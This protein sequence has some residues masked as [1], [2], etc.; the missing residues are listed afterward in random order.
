MSEQTEQTTTEPTLLQESPDPTR[1]GRSAPI[2]SDAEASAALAEHQAALVRV[3]EQFRLDAAHFESATADWRSAGS[4][5]EHAENVAAARS[6][7]GSAA[8]RAGERARFLTAQVE[9]VLRS[10]TA[11]ARAIPVLNDGET[12]RAADLTGP[13]AHAFAHDRLPDLIAVARDAVAR[14]DRPRMSLALRYGRERLKADHPEDRRDP[15]Q[16]AELARVLADV[17]ARLTP[18]RRDH[19][20][21]LAVQLLEAVDQFKRHEAQ[22]VHRKPKP[23]SEYVNDLGEV[24]VSWPAEDA[25]R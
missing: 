19:I 20:A 11:M 9:D 12:H 24:R 3:R 25:V 2:L 6:A 5:E 8:W 18:K 14:D 10:R 15:E 23:N 7:F 21:E 17:A 1:V 4:A 16:G 22:P 13:M